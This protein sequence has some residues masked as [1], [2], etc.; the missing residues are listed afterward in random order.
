VFR[1]ILY[2]WRAVARVGVAFV[3]DRRATMHV[4]LAAGI[5]P[6]VAAIGLAVDSSRGF[7]AKSRMSHALDIAVLAGARVYTSA[8]RDSDIQ[9]FFETNFP[10]G[11]LDATVEPLSI[12]PNDTDRTLTISARATIPTTFMQVVGI[13]TMSVSALAQATLESRSVEV[14]MVL[15]ITGSMSGQPIKDLR[16]AANNLVD[17]VVL[18]TQT[19]FYSKVALVPYAAAVNVGSSSLANQ[20][21]GTYTSGITCTTPTCQWY[22]YTNAN[23][24]VV[25]SPPQISNCVTA[26][27][28]AD[29]YTD[30]APSTSPVGRHYPT[31]SSACISNAIVPL[32]SN[33][34][35]LHSKINA[36]SAGGN[37]A[38]QIG[39]AWGWYMVSP[40][41]AYLWP[42]AS[43][44]AAYGTQDLLKV[45]II[46]TDGNFNTSYYNG[47]L[48]NEDTGD[49]NV[50]SKSEQ[51]NHA[52][53]NSPDTP[54]DQAKKLCD[55]MKDK[56]ILIYTV[57]LGVQDDAGASDVLNHC[58]TDSSHVYF[59]SNGTELKQ[60]FHDIAM[61]IAWLRLSK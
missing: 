60:A 17:I 43:Q 16:S 61:G 19:P 52:N 9:K 37:T 30:T 57:G 4:L 56:N 35:T 29:A 45:V 48:S 3:R 38:G 40:N 2:P 7:L 28:G 31:S 50:G 14:A 12:V 58:A 42:A 44:P 6:L 47:V 55:A 27:G 13:N 5:L 20:I 8:D 21:R 22:R 23:G 53:T 51:I 33:R 36:L 32:T 10:D 46:M 26:R 41:F 59:P 15:D 11:F 49:W 18:P 54:F 1:A 39:V 25:S 24:N 34:T